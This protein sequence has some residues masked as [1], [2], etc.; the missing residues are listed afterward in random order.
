MPRM[1]MFLKSPRSS[2]QAHIKDIM[3]LLHL[4]ELK[5]WVCSVEVQVQEGPGKLCLEYLKCLPCIHCKVACCIA[6]PACA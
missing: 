6:P 4:I 2:G 5:F 3:G 1:S